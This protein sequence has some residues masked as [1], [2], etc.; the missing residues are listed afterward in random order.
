M[1][2][3]FSDRAR[4]AMAYANWYAISTDSSHITP[5]HI[6]AGILIQDEGVAVETLRYLELS[7]ETIREWYGFQHRK[8]DFSV[9]GNRLPTTETA[10]N[11]VDRSI[12]FCLSNRHDG[13]GTEHLLLGWLSIQSEATD[14]FYRNTGLM[15]ETVEAK[16]VELLA[17]QR[18]KKPGLLTRLFHR[19]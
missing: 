3:R 18:D 14:V 15:I 19:K 8:E 13:V 5:D 17:G 16:V 9:Q 7:I 12:T 11:L 1:L 4:K 6:F 2:E 10:R